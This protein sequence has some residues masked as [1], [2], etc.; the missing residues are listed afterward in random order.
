MSTTLKELDVVFV[1]YYFTGQSA[2]SDVRTI[3]IFDN[4]KSEGQCAQFLAR[5]HNVTR[6]DIIIDKVDR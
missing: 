4:N 5:Y 1:W 6:Y 3:H 2:N